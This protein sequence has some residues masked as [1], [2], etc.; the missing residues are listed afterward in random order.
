MNEEKRGDA[1]NS[2][3]MLQT[4]SRNE[5][6]YEYQRIRS[7]KLDEGSGLYLRGQRQIM[8]EKSTAK[9]E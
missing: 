1:G 9:D 5:T 7:N 2:T 4:A 6:R 8:S 3:Y